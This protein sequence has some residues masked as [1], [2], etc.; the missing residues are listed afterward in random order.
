MRQGNVV[1]DGAQSPSLERI[2]RS[3]ERRVGGMD[4]RSFLSGTL[5][6]ALAVGAGAVTIGHT[7]TDEAWAWGT[8]HSPCG[9]SPLCPSSACSGT[10]T[11]NRN[12]NTFSCGS[13]NCSW[14]ESYCGSYIPDCGSAGFRGRFD[15]CDKCSRDGAGT[16]CSRT[17][18]RSLYSYYACICRRRIASC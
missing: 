13:G 18:C 15:C 5:K 3:V 8:C 4:R 10:R 7:W 2:R 6:A 9:P 16:R 12:Y 1:L 14:V 17:S 11:K